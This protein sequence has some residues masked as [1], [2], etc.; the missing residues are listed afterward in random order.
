MLKIAFLLQ[1]SFTMSSYVP[2]YLLKIIAS[3]L[4]CTVC[5]SCTMSSY[6]RAIFCWMKITVFLCT[7]VLWARIPALPSTVFLLQLHH[8]FVCPV[9]SSEDNSVSFTVVQWA[10]M[11]VLSSKITMFFFRMI[12]AIFWRKQCFFYSC[13][14]NSYDTCY[15]LK[16]T[17]FLL[18]LYHEFVC[19]V[20]SS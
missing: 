18:Q 12:R 4:T 9:L 6:P 1:L 11:P 5:S 20:L 7:D 2:S 16:I 19:S 15:L 14:M 8:E 10:R 3:L 13:T 17:V